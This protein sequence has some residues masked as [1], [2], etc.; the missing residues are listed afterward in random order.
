MGN[1]EDMRGGGDVGED[2]GGCVREDPKRKP[3]RGKRRGKKS[4]REEGR[5]QLAATMARWLGNRPI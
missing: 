1:G 4:I 3:L 2:V 5:V